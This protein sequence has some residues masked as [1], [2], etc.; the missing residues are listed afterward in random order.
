VGYQKTT[1]TV[2]EVTCGSCGKRLPTP[3]FASNVA[4]E[5]ISSEHR[6]M[7][8]LF[9]RQNR[10]K[11]FAN[12]WILCGDCAPPIEAQPAERAPKT[13][14]QIEAEVKARYKA[15]KGSRWRRF[16]RWLNA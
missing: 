4:F 10:W 13:M 15:A 5:P 7:V 16:V 12:E 2:W 11:P 6:R 14:A 9:A 8:N 1:L 3:V